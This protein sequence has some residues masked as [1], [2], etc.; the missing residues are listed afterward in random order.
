MNGICYG[1][2]LFSMVARRAGWGF[3][4]P[5]PAW[6]IDMLMTCCEITFISRISGASQCNAFTCHDEQK[7]LMVYVGY[8][9]SEMKEKEQRVQVKCCFLLQMTG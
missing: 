1:L 8:T 3:K 9:R 5:S 2:S 6:A 7:L 4:S